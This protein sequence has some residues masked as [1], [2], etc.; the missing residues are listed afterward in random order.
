MRTI[1]FSLFIALATFAQCQ[2]SRSEARFFVEAD[3]NQVL[4]GNPFVL[5][6][7]AENSNGGDFKAPDWGAVGLKPVGS[8]QSSS[9]SLQ[10]GVTKSAQS[11]TFYVEPTRE[12]EVT[13]PPATLMVGVKEFKTQPIVLRVLANPDGLIEKPKPRA[14]QLDFGEENDG[15]VPEPPPPPVEPEK[16]KRKTVRI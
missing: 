7:T 3:T 6:F 16:P 4:I 5:T 15:S 2:N 13:V 9:F 11:W 10:G 1:F 8:S 14:R 12:G